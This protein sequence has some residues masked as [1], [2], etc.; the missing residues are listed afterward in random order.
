MGGA[1]IKYAQFEDKNFK[2]FHDDGDNLFQLGKLDNDLQLTWATEN[3]L[4][5]M[6]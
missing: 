4:L 1:I 2:W 3:E 5:S 6:F